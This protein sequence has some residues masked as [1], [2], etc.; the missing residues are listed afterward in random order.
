MN[1]VLIGMPGCGK[2]TVGGEL[3]RRLGRSFYDADD[4]LVERE[5]RTIAELFAVSE[6]VFR[7]AE[8]RTITFLAQQTQA[9][10]AVGGGAVL[11]EE[12]MRLCK[13]SGR[14][15]FIDRPLEDIIADVD[16]STRP[17]LAEGKQKMYRLYDE[18]IELYRRYADYV[19]QTA[20]FSDI[21]PQLL[22]V[23]KEEG[24]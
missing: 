19:V 23:V 21:V 14:V 6:A 24:L 1:I 7:D 10:I 4:V 11:R 2:T 3:A 8:T 18:R 5:Q 16:T 20:D 17:L 12:N 9:V 15:F 13:L 22:A